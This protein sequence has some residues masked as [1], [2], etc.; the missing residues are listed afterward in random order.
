MI[1]VDLTVF[2]VFAFATDFETIN[3]MQ[4]FMTKGISH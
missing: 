1:S 4:R 3:E 2:R